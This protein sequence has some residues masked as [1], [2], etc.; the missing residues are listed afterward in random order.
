MPVIKLDYTNT[1]I[2]DTYI[3]DY[4]PAT[5]FGTSSPISVGNASGKLYRMLLRFNLNL[6]PNNAIINS[7]EITLMT[8]NGAAVT[9]N[10]HKV[11]SD[12]DESVT[13]WN[14]QP[15][16]NSEIS[17]SFITPGVNAVA[18]KINIKNIVQDWVNGEAN[19]G[20]VIEND[21]GANT[22]AQFYAK[23]SSTPAYRP[24]LT[25]DYSIPETGKKQVESKDAYVFPTAGGSSSYTVSIPFA[26]DPGDMLIAY[27]NTGSSTTDII[28]PTGWNLVTTYVA[29]MS[30]A[31]YIFSKI[32]DGTETEFQV[33][34]Q[35]ASS[36]PLAATVMRYKNVKKITPI[37]IRELAATTQHSIGFEGAPN[38]SL[39]VGM[40]ATGGTSEASTVA[41]SF[42]FASKGSAGGMRI[43]LVESYNYKK[44]SYTPGD[45][46]IAY[47][48]AA[49]GAYQVLALEPITNQAPNIDGADENLGSFSTPLQKEYTV[50]DNE[51]DAVTIVE[52]LDGVTINTKNTAGTNMLDLTAQW[53]D[54]AYGKH[55]V[56]IEVNDAY[57]PTNVSIRTFTFLKILSPEADLFEAIKGIKNLYPHMQRYKDELA[58]ILTSKGL[59]S[60]G[61]ESF[62]SLI[63]KVNEVA[64]NIRWAS[65]ELH[66]DQSRTDIVITGLAFRPRHIFVMSGGANQMVFN[67]YPDEYVSD[68][69]INTRVFY[70]G[71]TASYNTYTFTIADNGFSVNGYW[72][73]DMIQWV[74]YG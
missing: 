53:D 18:A 5:V 44:T 46:T 17:S 21:I 56:T 59:P 62:V 60:T 7:A 68:Q 13:N 73:K 43:T 36:F 39:I 49:A 9:L 66:T 45:T 72:A 67:Y 48:G 29:G 19:Y 10:I 70:P 3:T 24:I 28:T 34:R 42:R 26:K 8:S 16:Y 52:K 61:I 65:G 57:D 20:I 23:E 6:I 27:L 33:K 37:A 47:S 14:N 50:T 15:T 11:T 40:N 63:N 55:T 22:T 74:A 12:W 32:S 69:K 30:N 31:I 35:V 1:Q 38:N 2:A 41:L 25:I 58:A 51:N 71:G 64:G 54:L 4:S